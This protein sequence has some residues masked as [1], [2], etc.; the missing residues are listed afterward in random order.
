M[1]NEK[2]SL[3]GDW[4]FEIDPPDVGITA[5]WFSRPLCGDIRLP[6]SLQEQGFGEDVA[7][8]T[9]WTGQIVDRSWYTNAKYDRYHRPG[10]VKVP[11]WL[12]PDKHYVGAAWYQREI[13]IPVD[14]VDRRVI[15]TLERPHI[16]ST[17]WLDGAEFGSCD[18]LSTAHTYDLGCVP[19]GSHTLTI[20][21]DNRMSVDVGINSHSVTDHTQSNWNGIIGAIDLATKAETCFD[22][23]RAYPN[24]DERS[25]RLDIRT[26]RVSLS[27]ESHHVNVQHGETRSAQAAIIWDGLNGHADVTIGLG[28]NAA[29]WDEFE[30]HLQE[31]IVELRAETGVVDKRA[32]AFGLR[33]ISVKGT[34]FVVNGRATFMRGTLECCVFPITG[35]PPTDL[36]SWERIFAICKAHGLNH[37]RFHS[38][39]P[40]EAAFVAADN[41]GVY[42]QIECSSWANTTTA[43]G[44]GLPIDDW[45]Y[46][47]AYGI[48]KAYGNHPSFV[49][50]AYGNEPAGKIEEYLGKWVTHFKEFDRRRLYTSAGGWPAI[51]ASD[52]HNLPEPRIQAWGEELKS[53]INALPPETVTDYSAYVATTDKPTISHEIGQWCVYPDFDEIKRYEGVLKPMNFEIFQETLTE[54]H[55]GD[56]ARDFLIA[57]GKLQILCYKEEIESALRTPGFG[58]FHLLQANDFPGQGTALVGW[59]D[60]FWNE[61]GYITAPEFA[62]FCSDVTILARLEK[63]VFAQSEPITARID[64]A[65]Y[66]KGDLND[67]NVLWR[68]LDESCAELAGG[69]IAAP[70]VRQGTVTE[71]GTIHVFLDNVE[72]MRVRLIVNVD[73][74]SND[75]DLWV[76]PDAVPAKSS[77][78][79]VVTSE[80]DEAVRVCEG[81]GTA[82]LMLEPSQVKVDSVTGF[83]TVF[84]NTAWTRNQAPHTLGILCDPQHPV[85]KHFPTDSHTDWQWWE[86]IHGASAM[87]LDPMPTDLRALVQPID[88]W[89]ENRR[90]GLVIEALLGRGKILVTSMDLHSKL[91]ERLV[92]RQFRHSLLAYAHST[93]FEPKIVIQPTDLARLII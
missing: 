57:S 89:F 85:F 30:P 28:A 8:E 61:K 72:P 7:L 63:R 44:E 24:I 74:R 83:S 76:M 67:T 56:Q 82:V 6:G 51:P 36:A 45:L 15:L 4:K 35:Y 58:G 19:T 33:E 41:A 66:G 20:R 48:L 54:N 53:R 92:A 84:W 9:E 47:E 71:V 22:D 17:V 78:S 39:C 64:I 12:Q 86:L 16:K 81:G 40:P 42:L 62:R 80:V 60:P 75:W 93:D 1:N 91:D 25:V 59:L 26:R 70:S 5:Q 23:I 69:T 68:L 90:L 79:V 87:T 77:S 18:S 38:W 55:M 21:I 10:N 31:I 52:Y 37:V 2:I 46:T 27:D 73:D 32:V 49:L 14:W 34:Q 88:T 11:F 43:I 3:H 65:N 29:L 50:M 13:N